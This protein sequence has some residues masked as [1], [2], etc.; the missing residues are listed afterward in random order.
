MV[1]RPDPELIALVREAIDAG[2]L[3][4]GS[5][6]A[7]IACRVAIEGQRTLSPHDRAIWETCVLPILAKPLAPQILIASLNR[8]GNRL[9]KRAA[10]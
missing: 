9:P 5:M 3:T 10:A 7:A 8:R 2:L 6:E 4:E 1:P